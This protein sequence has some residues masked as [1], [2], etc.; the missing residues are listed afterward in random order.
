MEVYIFFVQNIH[1]VMEV[2]TDLSIIIS[3]ITYITFLHLC[4]Y[5]T[6]AD[7]LLGQVKCTYYTFGV[8]TWIWLVAIWSGTI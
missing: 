3:Y 5:N 7:S 1:C 8:K 4:V 6:F 2:Y